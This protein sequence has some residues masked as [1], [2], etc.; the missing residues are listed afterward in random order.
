MDHEPSQVPQFDSLILH[1]GSAQHPVSFCA[2]QP[3]A[4]V[5]GGLLVVVGVLLVVEGV[6]LVVVGVLLVV[7]GV[8]PVVDATVLSDF[9]QLRANPIPIPAPI[10]M[11]MT[12]AAIAP[13]ERPFDFFFLV[14]EYAFGALSIY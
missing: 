1:H 13:L 8:R 10:K 6:L 7:V 3:N 11:I 4:E 2:Q 9:P 12:M 14:V 5:E